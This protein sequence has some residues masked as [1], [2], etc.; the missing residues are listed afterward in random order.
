[1][2][3]K[4]DWPR[5]KVNHIRWWKGE[6]MA[7]WL[8]APRAVP[9]GPTPEPAR[10][11]DPR[12]RWTDPTYRVDRDE[13][14]LARAN[15]YAEAFPHLSTQIGP[16]SLG[17]FLGAEPRFAETTVW[18]DPCIDDPNTYG[19]IRFRAEGNK[20]L[21]VHQA[22]IDEALRRCDGRYVV[23]M[24]DLI[25]NMDTLAAMRDTERLM[26]D[27]IERP[28]WV[29]EKLREIN[30]AFFDSF[31][32]IGDRVRD[33]GGGNAFVFNIWGPGKTAK[34][35]CDLACMLSPAMFRRFVVPPLAAQ[36]EWLDYSLFHLDGED[37]I[38]HLDALLEIDAL[39][40]V[41]WTPRMVSTGDAQEAGGSPKWY[42]L[43]RRI[44]SARKS[45]QAIAV[46]AGSLR[47][48]RGQAA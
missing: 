9:L 13:W 39:S 22:L 30:Q 2:K 47:Y 5:A 23:G 44:K 40:A 41:E 12:E 34:V 18:Y 27:L 37:A 38:P 8:T 33:A 45:V 21:D 7:L 48:P 4:S 31:D 35:Q 28:E 32:L 46:Q 26:T 16:G 19:P 10:P 29:E 1:M 42:D 14:E 24:P 25:E 3:W 6:G 15:H 43:Y 20:W 36:C 11:G 17:T